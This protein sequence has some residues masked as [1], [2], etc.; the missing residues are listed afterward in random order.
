MTPRQVQAWLMLGEARVA[1]ERAMR[2]GDMALASQGERD[3]IA[4]AI[5][6]LS[7]A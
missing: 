6:E 5:R 2:L 7:D 3:A 1:R 4:R